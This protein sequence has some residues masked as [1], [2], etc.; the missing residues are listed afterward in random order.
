M[1]RVGPTSVG[2]SPLRG[3]LMDLRP[4]V[5][6]DRNLTVAALLLA[7]PLMWSGI[8]V[9]RRPTPPSAEDGAGRTGGFPI[10]EEPEAVWVDPVTNLH[11]FVLTIW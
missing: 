1:A 6:E 8:Q 9:N 11:T 10:H 4:V 2:A 7:C 5:G 3:A